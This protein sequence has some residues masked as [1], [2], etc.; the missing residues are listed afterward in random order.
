MA[1]QSVGGGWLP[2][3][4]AGLGVPAQACGAPLACWPDASVHGA[5]RQ[6]GC[7]GAQYQIRPLGLPRYHARR[8][9]PAGGGNG[10]G[11]H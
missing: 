11:R 4:S 5:E 7:V 8:P 6:G 1:A 2:V 10:R 3:T 9:P